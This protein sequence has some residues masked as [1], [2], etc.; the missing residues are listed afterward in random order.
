MSSGVQAH[1]DRSRRDRENMAPSIFASIA[2]KRYVC[3]DS[4]Q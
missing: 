2:T 1:L 4:I 3:Y